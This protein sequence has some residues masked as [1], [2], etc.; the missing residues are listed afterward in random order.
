M[1]ELYLHSSTCLHGIVFIACSELSPASLHNIRLS[2]WREAD[3][4]ASASAEVKKTWI[5]KSTSPYSFSSL[6]LTSQAQD[7]V[8]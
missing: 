1:V 5:Y 4:S 7:V 2:P 6:F 3:H 8:T